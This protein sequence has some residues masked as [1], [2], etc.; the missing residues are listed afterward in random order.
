MSMRV[1]ILCTDVLF[2]VRLRDHVIAAGGVPVV[3]VADDP[4]PLDIAVIDLGESRADPLAAIRALR[5]RDPALVIL[6]FASHVRDDQLAG[7]RTAGCTDVVPRSRI[8]TVLQRLLA[9]LAVPHRD[10]PHD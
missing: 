7:G 4:A 5:Q 1:A 8:D 9:R 10:N 6:G 2:R 3:L